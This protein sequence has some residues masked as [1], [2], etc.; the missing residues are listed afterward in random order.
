M[1]G[2]HRLRRRS[3]DWQRALKAGC[4]VECLGHRKAERIERTVA[5]DAM[6]AWRLTAMT[7]WGRATPELPAEVLHAGREIMA[8]QDFAADRRLPV[9]GNPG[10]VVPTLALPGGYRNRRKNRPPG[11]PKL[12]EGYKRLAVQA[13]GCERVIRMDRAGK[14]D[15]RLSSDWLCGQAARRGGLYHELQL[16]FEQRCWMSLGGPR[17]DGGP[18][19]GTRGQ[20]R[21]GLTGR[22]ECAKRQALTPLRLGF[23][24]AVRGSR[25]RV[26]R[27]GG[28]G[29]RRSRTGGCPKATTDRAGD[30]AAGAGPLAE[31]RGGGSGGTWDA[32]VDW[33]RGL[34]VGGWRSVPTKCPAVGG[35]PGG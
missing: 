29:R 25:G 1:L 12:G 7:L 23:A 34:L 10:L 30:P 16:P 28:L 20:A 11:Q 15:Q 4:Q 24:G 19:A 14:L 33:R 18:P 8:L 13:Q 9:P 35:L 5:T 31:D 26:A 2:W 3:E 21:Y 17:L 32:S 27:C 22:R 6:I